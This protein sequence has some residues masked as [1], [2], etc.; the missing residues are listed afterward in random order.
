[1]RDLYRCPGS[2]SDTIDKSLTW[3]S[4]A[5]ADED[6]PAM[7]NAGWHE[8]IAAASVAPA[9]A[10]QAVEAPSSVPADDAPPTRAEMEAEAKRRGIKVDGRWSDAR[11]LQVLA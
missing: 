8:S 1:M 6:V 10:P 11:L 3:D 5:V 4:V 2:I 7:L 9:L